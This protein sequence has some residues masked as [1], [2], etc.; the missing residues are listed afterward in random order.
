MP[1]YTK[2]LPPDEYDKLSL[3]EKAAY[4]SDMADV[5]KSPGEP[6]AQAEPNPQAESDPPADATPQDD[7]N[8]PDDNPKTT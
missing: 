8:P 3:D 5:L 7:P 6:P 4:I 1:K 2:L